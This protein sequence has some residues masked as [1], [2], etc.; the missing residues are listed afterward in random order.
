[1]QIVDGLEPE[2]RRVVTLIGLRKALMSLNDGEE[3]DEALETWG[4]CV[5]EQR[6]ANDE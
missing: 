3:P 1:M 4:D 5:L 2:W 6:G